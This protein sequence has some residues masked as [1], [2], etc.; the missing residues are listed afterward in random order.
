MDAVPKT[1]PPRFFGHQRKGVPHLHHTSRA[2]SSRLAP[3]AAVEMRNGHG[4][5][6]WIS[7]RS[8]LEKKSG[9]FTAGCKRQETGAVPT[10]SRTLCFEGQCDV[11]QTSACTFEFASPP[12]PVLL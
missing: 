12:V 7:H 5:G 4:H 9:L 11:M 8:L 1:I 10:K 6:L 3:I 2:D